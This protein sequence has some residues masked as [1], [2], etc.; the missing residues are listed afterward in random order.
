MRWLALG[1]V[2]LLGSG[3]ALF[4]KPT[5]TITIERQEFINSWAV[6]KVLYQRMRAQ[7]AAVCIAETTLPRK[8]DALDCAEL[9]VIDRKAKALAI[10][11]EAKIA[12]PEAELDW[13]VIK[14]ILS[15][16]VGLVP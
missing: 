10:Q 7:A 4:T 6:T 16:L 13:V 2:L 3:C 11:V 1:L 14:D 9:A 12:T 5:G 15:L 8:L